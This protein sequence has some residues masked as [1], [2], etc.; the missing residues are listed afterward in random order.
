MIESD[1]L[2]TY[3]PA[4]QKACIRGVTVIGQRVYSYARIYSGGGEAQQLALERRSQ[5]AL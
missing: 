2:T 5:N 3:L 4:V 1:T